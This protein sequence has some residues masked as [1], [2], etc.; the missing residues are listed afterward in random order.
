MFRS[1]NRAFK[2]SVYE[3]GR[4]RKRGMPR[5]LVI[6]F[7]GVIIGAGGY[8]FL[9]T[10]YG[11]TRITV[12]ESQQL[13]QQIINLNQEQYALQARGDELSQNLQQ[14]ETENGRLLAQYQEAEAKITQLNQE[15]DLLRRAIP[16]DP[17]GTPVGLRHATLTAE[18][19]KLHYDLLLMKRQDQAADIN[20]TIET[21]VEGRYRNG[22]LGRTSPE[23]FNATVGTMSQLS[24]ELEFDE[25]QRTLT[26]TV[27][28]FTVKNAASGEVLGRRTFNVN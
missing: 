9:Q 27:V 26:A 15:I 8:W 17:G 7:T 4:R 1:S 10:N 3:T 5:W 6:L 28:T 18:L 25:G 20:V 12:E 11:P 19:G 16:Q 22:R 13:N 2:P 23:P 14:T 24:G 21:A